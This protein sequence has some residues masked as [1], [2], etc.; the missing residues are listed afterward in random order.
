LKGNFFKVKFSKFKAT[1][2]ILKKEN[3]PQELWKVTLV[4]YDLRLQ[5]E[6][7]LFNILVSSSEDQGKKP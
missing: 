2:T 5:V 1:K 7:K 4:R 3:L 6:I